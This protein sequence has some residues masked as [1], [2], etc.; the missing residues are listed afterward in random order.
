M[1]R[2]SEQTVGRLTVLVAAV[3][4]STN[5]M[6]VKSPLFVE[7]PREERGMLL[8][9]WRALFAVAALALLVRSP[10][11]HWRL[12]PMALSFV[13]MNGVFLQSMVWTTAGNAIWLQN[14]APLWICLFARLAGETLDRRD[15]P[16]LGLVSAGIGLILSCELS[17]TDWSADAPRGVLLGALSGVGYALVI[18]FLRKLRDLDSA[19]LITVNLA[20][21]ALVF[22]AAPIVTGIWP[23]GPQ[24]PVLAAFGALQ[25]AAPYF[26]FAR[27]LKK[28]SSQEGACLGL[29]EPVLVPMWVLLLYQ[30]RPAWWTAVGGGLILAG[31]LWRYWPRR[32]ADAEIPPASAVS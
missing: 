30:E 26:L 6:F 3:L 12:L 4:W 32:P 9:F 22:S 11:W 10:R 1:N 28:I 21:T 29:L 24:W 20:S 17:A 2:L 23:V 8:A 15:L 25:L 5:G 19:W 31:L 7:W 18:Y 27:G 14:I 16:M 13:V